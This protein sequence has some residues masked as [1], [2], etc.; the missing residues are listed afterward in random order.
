[1]L[2]WKLAAT[3][4]K[5]AFYIAIREYVYYEAKINLLSSE[6]ILYPY[7]CPC[8]RCAVKICQTGC[9]E[10]CYSQAYSM[11]EMSARIFKEAGVIMRQIEMFD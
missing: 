4:L 5:V 8:L 9:R 6:G 1:M 7:R 11:D 10:V 3:V 2:F